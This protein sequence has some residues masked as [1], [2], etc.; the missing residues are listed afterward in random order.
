MVGT[1]FFTMP[2]LC[3][4]SETNGSNR[5]QTIQQEIEFGEDYLANADAVLAAYH[6]Q[7]NSKNCTMMI[8]QQ[9]QTGNVSQGT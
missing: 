2:L 5:R 8:T 1:P 6:T 7:T 3:E 4:C 9:H